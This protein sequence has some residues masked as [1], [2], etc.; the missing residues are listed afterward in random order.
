MCPATSSP[1][2]QEL[3]QH[4]GHHRLAS[5]DAAGGCCGASAD[6]VG[7]CC[8]ASETVFA[9]LASEYVVR[10]AS[11]LDTRI[12]P[13]TR[14]R[15]RRRGSECRSPATTAPP[16]PMGPTA[17]LPCTSR[18]LQ[19]PGTTGS[20]WWTRSAGAALPQRDWSPFWH[21]SIWCGSLRH[22]LL[23]SRLPRRSCLADGDPSTNC[24]LPPHHPLE[25]APPLAPLCSKSSSRTGH[26]RPSLAD[27]TGGSCLGDT[28]RLMGS[29]VCGALQ[30]WAPPAVV[31][32]TRPADAAARQRRRRRGTP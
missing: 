10:L 14:P 21:P 28:D 22:S 11:A 23:A 4:T 31:W 3:F 12:P 9:V 6:A 30:P 1:P 32:P 19:A 29:R 8:G 7:G 5:V 18:A 13:P 26:H 27:A 15:S 2:L 16:T 20:C 17:V 25:C 24:R